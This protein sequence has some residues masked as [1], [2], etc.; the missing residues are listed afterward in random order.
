MFLK[1]VLI[2]TLITM[3]GFAHAGKTLGI[4][5]GNYTGRG[6]LQTDFLPDITFISERKLDNGIINAVTK[7]VILS[8]E[9]TAASARLKIVGPPENFTVIDLATNKSAGHGSCLN[10]HC[11]F[12]ATVMGGDL[13]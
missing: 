5:D 13:T 2:M 4:P 10:G 9:I 11:T 6:E 8:H 12:T 1:S 3:T 7:V